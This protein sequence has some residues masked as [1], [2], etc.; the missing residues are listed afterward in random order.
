MSDMPK[1]QKIVK[2]YEL[3]KG[4]RQN[5]DEHWQDLAEY[6]IPNKDDVY[7]F[8]IDGERK[9]NLLYDSTSIHSLEMLSASLHG[10]LTNPASVWFGLSTG[11]TALDMEPEVTT[12]LQTCTRI[13]IDTLNQTNFQEEIHET[14]LDLGGIGTT[15]LEIEEDD[16]DDVRFRSSP[17]YGSY[18]AENSKGVVD[19]L[20]RGYKMS[21]RNIR[22]KFGEEVFVANYDL[23]QALQKDPEQTEEII[24]AIYP[25][26]DEKKRKKGRFEACTVLRKH[27]FVLEEKEFHSWPFAVPR[28]TKLNGEVYGRA[29]SMKCLA[30]VKMLN[31]VMKTTIRGMQKAVDPPLMV[32]DSGFLLPINTTPSGTNF[33]RAGMKDRIEP[34]PVAARPDIGLD[35]VENIRS[36][37]R[38]SF[39]WDQLQLINQRDMTATEV[40]QR[41]D[42]RL[43]FLGPILGRLNNELLKPIIDRV[44]DILTRRGRYPKPPAALKDKPNLKIVYTSQIAKAQRTGEANVLLKVLQAC[45]PMLEV[46]PDMLDNI[47]GDGVIQY[48]AN[49]FGLPHEMLNDPKQVK[50]TRKARAEAQAAAQQAQ[51]ENMQADTQMKAAKAQPVA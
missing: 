3:Q 31:A 15:V 16:D 26:T 17:I 32:P 48:A 11:D 39:F 1:G 45:G 28:W 38:E 36:R 37:V 19:K 29:P 25:H 40:M 12:Y 9:H 50:A 2:D 23:G 22:E 24:F 27:N 44:F 14:Y 20:W 34:F 18:V 8:K 6:F 49:I 51:M 10:M 21:L 46:Q 5:W 7:G 42:E 4:K 13:T 43:R 33:Y 30:D 47:N 35:F 41:T